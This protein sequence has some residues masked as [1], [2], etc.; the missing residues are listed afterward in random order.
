LPEPPKR[1]RTLV[2]GA[3]KAAAS[4]ARAVEQ[5]WVGPISGVVVTQYGHTVPTDK[6]EIIE[7]AHPVPDGASRWA[8]ERILRQAGALTAKDLLLCLWSGGGSSLMALPAPGISMDDKRQITNALLRCG[9]SISEINVVRKHISAIKGGRLAVAAYP[10]PIV[11][12][13]VSDVPGDDPSLIASGP[14]EADS[15]TYAQACAIIAKYQIDAPAAVLL[16][17]AAAAGETPKPGDPRLV[18]ARGMVIASPQ[19]AL[20]AAAK[21]A[22]ES[23][24]TPIILGSAIEGEAREVAKVHAGIINQM[25]RYGQPA[26]APAVLLSGGETSVTLR[27]KGKGGRNTEFLL[28]LALAL[29]ADHP[30]QERIH[31]IACDTDGH[32]GSEDNA[33][34]LLY[35]DTLARAAALGLDG[36]MALA[37]NDAYTF[38]AA[39][40]DLVVC[41]P[42]LTN[43]NDFRAILLH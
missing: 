3:G 13:V 7:A 4:M 38:F 24:I 18:N 19:M 5:H 40:N 10:A 8:A 16:Y 1:G 27:G 2:V 31:A 37:D 14:T 34:A 21:L 29:G 9:A 20:E 15:S 41:G 23:G 6:I 30:Y 25:A 43:V 22:R 17:L 12:L 36:R 11:S 33:G 42:T 28:A 32:D 39:L 35:P 26:A